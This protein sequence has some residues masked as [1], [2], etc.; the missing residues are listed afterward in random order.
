MRLEDYLTTAEAAQ[1]T[2]YSLPHIYKLIREQ[3]IKVARFGKAYLV[4]KQSLEN[5]KPQPVG[6]PRGSAG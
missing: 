6:R 4:E 5:Y 2:G 1:F 3:K